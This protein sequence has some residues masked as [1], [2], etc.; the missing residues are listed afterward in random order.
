MKGVI[1]SYLFICTLLYLMNKCLAFLSGLMLSVRIKKIGDFFFYS[2]AKKR[3]KAA[4]KVTPYTVNLDKLYF[5]QKN[6]GLSTIE[7]TN[8]IIYMHFYK[9]PKA[10]ESK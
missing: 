4:G 9:H 3:V 7:N 2:V 10:K 8:G 6:N 5:I 1:D